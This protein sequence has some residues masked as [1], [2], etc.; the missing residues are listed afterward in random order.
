METIDQHARS[1]RAR[2]PLQGLARNFEKIL[3]QT[4]QLMGLN[5]AACRRTRRAPTPIV[6]VKEEFEHTIPAFAWHVH[7]SDTTP[8]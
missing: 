5:E 6:S 2:S 4:R 3:S 7:M 8:Q 1:A